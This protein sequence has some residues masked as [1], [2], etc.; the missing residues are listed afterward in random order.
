MD[1]IFLIIL[2]IIVAYVFILYKV[3]NMVDTPSVNDQI[4]QAV[5]D[6]Y[7]ADVE[8]I[9]NLSNTATQL[10]TGGL[11]VP[12]NIITKGAIKFP[13][14]GITHPD[15]AD[16]AIYKA[17]GQLQIAVDDL[18]RFRNI[19]T[20]KHQIEFNTASGSATFGGNLNVGGNTINQDGSAV[21]GNGKI[22]IDKDGNI[23]INGTLNMKGKI[24]LNDNPIMIRGAT[25]TNHYMQFD[26]SINGPMIA[27]CN[28]VGVKS[29]C[30]Q[31]GNFEVNGIGMTSS[32]G[33]I[34]VN[35]GNNNQNGS[36]LSV[37]NSIPKLGD[38]SWNDSDDQWI[39]YPG[40]KLELYDGVD[41]QGTK[42]EIS[43]YDGNSVKVKYMGEA[44]M[45]AGLNST[46][47]LKLYYKGKEVVK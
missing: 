46:A 24:A 33:A 15:D 13:E 19:A 9:R 18:L 20:K 8:A 29:I 35:S 4:K 25:D 5:K 40:Y 10:Q 12:G 17:D 22:L 14:W 45:G 30:T 38:Y 3:E 26:E 43:N 28:G 21:L 2:C 44:G 31:K 7:L 32:I 42:A 1:F 37:F 23:T 34:G 6:I 41:Y 36:V 16:G 39:V 27:G 47:S 11:T